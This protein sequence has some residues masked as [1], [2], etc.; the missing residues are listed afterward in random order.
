MAVLVSIENARLT[1]VDQV[2]IVPDFVAYQPGF[3]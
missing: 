2:E 3:E 1:S